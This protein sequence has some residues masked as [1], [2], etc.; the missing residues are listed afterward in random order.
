MNDTSL[1]DDGLM[2]NEEDDVTTDIVMRLHIM[3]VRGNITGMRRLLFEEA[4]QDSFWTPN[5]DQVS[6]QHHACF[7]II[8]MPVCFL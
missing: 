3:A 5:R 1:H 7:R 2:Q 4:H 8:M 6:N